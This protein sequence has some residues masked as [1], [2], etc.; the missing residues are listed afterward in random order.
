MIEPLK[1]KKS[2]P[3][4]TTFFTNGSTLISI[5]RRRVN[6]AEICEREA[7]LFAANL[8]IDNYGFLDCVSMKHSSAQ[9]ASAFEY[10]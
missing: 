10:P 1:L 2:S 9:I 6:V 3:S 7:N 5:I 8:L 4:W